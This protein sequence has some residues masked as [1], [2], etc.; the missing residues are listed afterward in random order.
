[1]HTTLEGIVVGRHTFTVTHV[2]YSTDADFDGVIAKFEAATGD[3]EDGGFARELAASSDAADFEARMKAHEG[4]SGFMRFLMLDH[5]AWLT[6]NGQPAKCR[7]YTM[8]NPLIARTML[9]YDIEVGLNVPVR[10]I[11]YEATDGSTRFA[12]DLP[13]SLMSRLENKEVA[14]A[15]AKLDVKLA[16]L[17]ER[18]TGA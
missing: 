4:D 10:L 3:I 7:L 5:G 11:I 16:A 2:E 1:M 8:G 15:A 13:S 12:Y 9:K 14:A 6:F 18:V 17:A